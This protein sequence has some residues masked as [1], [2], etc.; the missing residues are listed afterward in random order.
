MKWIRCWDQINGVVAWGLVQNHHAHLLS[1]YRGSWL[2][3]G[4]SQPDTLAWFAARAAE[5][6]QAPAR[7]LSDLRLLAPVD[8]QEI[9]AA[10]VTYQRSRTAR[11][12]ESEC[13]A[14]AYDRVYTATRPELFFKALPEKVSGPGQPVGVRRDSRWTVPEPELA[15]VIDSAERVVGC[16]LGNDMSARDIEGENLLYLPQA[17]IYRC[18]C[19]LGPVLRVGVPEEE[20]LAWSLRMRILR[21]GR[22]VFD[23]E[24]SVG[25]LRRRFDELAGFLA[26]SQELPHGA[27]VLT[28]TGIVPPDEFAVQEGDEVHI[29][30]GPL[31]VLVNPVIRV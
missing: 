6:R 1:D 23:G 10:G 28:G 12:E 26:R 11:M 25:R 3:E 27:V 13:S 2:A 7:P 15:L 30:C 16:M 20:M 9:W 24:T 29:E 18:S 19:A 4:L 5:A 22:V 17:K 21:K 8:R 14:S 31:G